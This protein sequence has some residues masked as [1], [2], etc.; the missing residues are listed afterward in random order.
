MCVSGVVHAPAC[1]PVDG[2]A[3]HSMV[4]SSG[5]ARLAAAAAESALR[6][7][8][9]EWHHTQL[10]WQMDRAARDAA[11][12]AAQRELSRLRTELDQ[13]HVAWSATQRT[14]RDAE[15]AAAVAS[16]RAEQQLADA[17]AQGHAAQ[18][19]AARLQEQLT[20]EQEAHAAAAAEDVRRQLAK[21]ATEHMA[22]R[23]E[24]SALRIECDALRQRLQ[25]VAPD[26]ADLTVDGT[27][28]DH[29]EVVQ[30]LQ[31]AHQADAA[32]WRA[33]LSQRNTERDHATG[34]VSIVY[35]GLGVT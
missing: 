18:Q 3:Y 34:M 26:R 28:R 21:E 9:A 31:A 14:L 23:A 12:P 30:R 1:L 16:T 35:G 15:A 24:L 8:D 20:A 10:Q 6:Q 33:L 32:Q 4:F 5:T 7:K 22:T 17:L 27:A 13:T 19:W 29:Q 2:S 11:L 25:D